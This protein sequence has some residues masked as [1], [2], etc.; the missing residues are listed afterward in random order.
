MGGIMGD[1]GLR[2]LSRR[3]GG[4]VR[5]RFLEDLWETVRVGGLWRGLGALQ[6]CCGRLEG[7]ADAGGG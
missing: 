6:R 3:L 1:R 7:A 5:M 4:L 2:R